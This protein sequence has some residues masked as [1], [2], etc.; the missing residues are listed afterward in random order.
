MR[1]VYVVKWHDAFIDTQDL[2][3]KKAKK[4]KPIVRYTVG[5]FVDNNEDC[6]VLATDYFEKGQEISSPMVI[7]QSWVLDVWEYV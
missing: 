6:I 1:P 3:V 5:F 2:T 4:L 7:P